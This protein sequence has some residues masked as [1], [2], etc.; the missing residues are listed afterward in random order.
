MRTSALA[1]SALFLAAC[2]ASSAKPA[3][4]Q[5]STLDGSTCRTLSPNE[6]TALAYFQSQGLTR[7][8]SAAIIGNLDQESTPNLDPHAEQSGGATGSG[9]GI[10][11]W[12]VG[13]RWDTAPNDNVLWYA[14]T[15]GEDAYSLDLQL[16]FICYELTTFPLYGLA[17]LQQAGD[18]TSATIAFETG[19]N[20]CSQC[21]EE[22]RVAYAEQ[23]LRADE[24]PCAEGDAATE[25]G[26]EDGGSD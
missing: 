10:A 25:G 5:G 12:T 15:K 26:A 24:A 19:F 2:G 23:V 21:F 17:P 6:R 14:S 13:Q 3:G 1:V 22:Q 8:Q 11:Q 16:A 9:V 18:V 20:R 7:T 4:H